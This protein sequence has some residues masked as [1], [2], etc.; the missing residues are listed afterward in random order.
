VGVNSVPVLLGEQKSL[1]LNKVTFIV[2]Y[3]LIVGLVVSGVA[4]PWI[5][6]TV[7]AVPRLI[8]VWGIYSRPKPT[9]KPDNWPVWPL[10][11]VGWAMHFNRFAGVLFIG[12]L[13]LSL[14]V[15]PLA[16]ALGI[17]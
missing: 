13:L 14:I 7:L 4:T 15:T 3:V 12:G 16:R 10:W 8:T 5:L 17:G 1:V 6:L 9:S 11:F 2:F